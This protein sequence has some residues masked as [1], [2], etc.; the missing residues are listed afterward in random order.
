MATTGPLYRIG[1]IVYLNESANLGE[2]EAYKIGAIQQAQPGRWVYQIFIEKR[3]PDSQ[4]VEDRD[5]LRF[6]HELFFD[7]VDLL[8]LC[9][10][11]NIALN[12]VQNR[13]NRLMNELTNCASGSTGTHPG[14]GPIPKGDARFSIGDNIFVKASA[15]LGFLETYKVT[16]I[17]KRPGVAEFMYELDIHGTAKVNN[18]YLNLNKF[19]QMFFREPELIDLCEALNTALIALDRKI[20]RL[21]AIKAAFCFPEIP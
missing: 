16:N 13:I 10:A 1:D 9:E 20:A 11:N 14:P 17:H 5:D 21:L 6:P 3:P 4:T 12:N 15:N 7:E 2:L 18:P 19:R 8:T